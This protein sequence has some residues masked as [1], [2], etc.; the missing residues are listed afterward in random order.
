M[1]SGGEFGRR[2][3]MLKGLVGELLLSSMVTSEAMEVLT[4]K[5]QQGILSNLLQ[6]FPK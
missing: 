1:I 6:L 4:N 2:L 3:L 5:R